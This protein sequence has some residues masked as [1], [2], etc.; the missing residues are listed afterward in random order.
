MTLP[1]FIICG[2]QKGGTTSLYYYLREHPQ[3]FLPSKK[4]IHFFDLNYKKGIDWYK[5]HFRGARNSNIKAIGEVTPSYMYLEEVPERI[6]EI[7]PDVKLIFILRNPI[8]RAYSHYWHEVALGYEWLP[9][10]E[11]IKAEEE[12]LTRGDIIS[13][14]HYSYLDRGKYIEQIRRFRKYFSKEQML[15]LITEELK[16]NP[17]KTMRRIFEF[18]QVDPEFKSERWHRKFYT[19]KRPRIKTLQYIR[20][21][22]HRISE[23]YYPQLAFLFKPIIYAIDKVNLRKGY[24][25]MNTNTRKFLIKYF[26]PYNKKLEEYL[27]KKLDQWYH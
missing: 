19:G 10:E 7:L 17:E 14:L 21:K 5:R 27:G 11:A 24:P 20:G 2:T 9:F 12:R 23:Y 8:D 18:L 13:R 4:E 1:N 25:E 16:S 26:E 22:L 15:I 6:H 3:I